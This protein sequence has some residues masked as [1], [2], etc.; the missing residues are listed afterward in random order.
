MKKKKNYA[1][2]TIETFNIITKKCNT[3]KEF[4]HYRKMVYKTDGYHYWLEF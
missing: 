4:E 3:R 1:L 2:M